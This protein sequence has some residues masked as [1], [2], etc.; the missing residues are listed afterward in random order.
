[1]KVELFVWTI[2]SRYISVSKERGAILS[3]YIS[4]SFNNSNSCTGYWYVDCTC[5]SRREETVVDY[6]E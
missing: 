5:A 3:R 2:L 4:V 6:Y 1:V